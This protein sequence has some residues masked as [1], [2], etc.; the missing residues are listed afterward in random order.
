M[1]H[2]GLEGVSAVVG[3]GEDAVGT[4]GV[5]RRGPSGGILGARRALGGGWRAGRSKMTR[6]WAVGGRED[7]SVNG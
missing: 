1:R 5:K 7:N 4:L 2:L 3:V 6:G